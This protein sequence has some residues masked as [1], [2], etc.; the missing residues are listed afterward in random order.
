[1]ARLFEMLKEDHDTVKGLLNRSIESRDTSQFSQI[2][3]MLEIHMEGEEKLLY[4]KLMQRDKER[5]LESYEEHHVGKLILKELDET[6]RDDETWIP[7]I[8]VL[9]DVLDHH[10][11]EEE[12]QI[13]DEARQMLDENQEQE[14]TRQFEELRSKR[15]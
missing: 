4:P 2:K 6:G 9:K 10:I 12:S 5:A 3:K 15:M 1:M 8:K 7:K 11:E 13:F 14:I